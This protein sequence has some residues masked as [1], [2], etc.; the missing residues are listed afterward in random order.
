MDTAMGTLTMTFASATAD[1]ST[2]VTISSLNTMI[3]NY[4]A[5]IEEE[6]ANM[7]RACYDEFKK[8]FDRDKRGRLCRSRAPWYEQFETHASKIED[9]EKKIAARKEEIERLVEQDSARNS[10]SSARA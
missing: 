9:Y 3:G 8:E 6:K 10:G 2:S 7:G 4:K 1:A 5:K